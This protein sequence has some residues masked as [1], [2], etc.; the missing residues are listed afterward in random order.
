MR[1]FKDKTRGGVPVRIYTQEAGGNTPIHGAVY[2]E[3]DDSWEINCWTEDG[4][5]IG[6]LDPTDL[7]LVEV[8]EK[9]PKMAKVKKKKSLSFRD[10]LKDL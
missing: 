8:K 3:D 5:E 7:D 2:N 6:Q 10:M 9:K 1:R 4:Y